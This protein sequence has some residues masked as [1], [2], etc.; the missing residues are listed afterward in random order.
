M[1]GDCDAMPGL[2]L[3]RAGDYLIRRV[4]A[5]EMDGQ[6]AS[7]VI[8]DAVNNDIQRHHPD[9]INVRRFAESAVEVLIHPF[10]AMPTIRTTMM[11]C[12]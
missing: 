12:W 7:E 2:L 5:A 6:N 10:R 11:N 1:G 9:G 8:H 4:E 3:S